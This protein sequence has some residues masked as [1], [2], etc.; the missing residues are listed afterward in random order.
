MP[1]FYSPFVA[2]VCI[3]TI[4]WSYSERKPS[5]WENIK[6][7]AS[8]KPEVYDTDCCLRVYKDMEL[9]YIQM[10]PTEMQIPEIPCK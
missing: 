10:Y 3:K 5:L 7:N 6:A 4:S 1:N 2:I 9:V 8:T